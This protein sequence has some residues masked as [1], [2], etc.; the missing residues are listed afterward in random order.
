MPAD[1]GKQGGKQIVEL[2]KEK[3]KAEALKKSAES[4]KENIDLMNKLM[5]AV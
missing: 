2:K 1:I 3:E 5:V 4:I